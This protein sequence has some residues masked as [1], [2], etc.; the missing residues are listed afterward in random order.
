M[1][2]LTPK[3]IIVLVL[4]IGCKTQVTGWYGPP[5]SGDTNGNSDIDTDSDSDVDSDSD[6]DT[7]T[8]SDTGSETDTCTETETETE[9]CTESSTDTETDSETETDTD[10][11]T[12]S[13]TDL[14][15]DCIGPGVYLGYWSPTEDRCWELNPPTTALTYAD[16]EARCDALSLDGAS[17]W[18]VPDINELQMLVDGCATAGCGVNDPGC[19][20]ETCD[21]TCPTCSLYGGPGGGGCYWDASLAG[22][23][24][25]AG[26]WSS[27]LQTGVAYTS[28]WCVHFGSGSYMFEGG[29]VAHVRCI[30]TP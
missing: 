5:D 29:A 12:D 6:A 27:S 9:T 8:E 7:E 24:S 19:L 17:D 30:R 28:R 4:L 20:D 11:E 14:P 1:K 3:V 26:Y 18:R 15:G 21:D 25:S 16:A 2:P 13:D 10:S 23:C 22:D